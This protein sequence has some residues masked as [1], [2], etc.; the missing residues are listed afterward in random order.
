MRKIISL[1][2]A[3][4]F[5]VSFIPLSL[6]LKLVPVYDNY[7]VLIFAM[8]VAA[9]MTEIRIKKKVWTW[10]DLG[11]RRDTL[12][13]RSI[14][15]YFSITVIYLAGFYL[16]YGYGKKD[17]LLKGTTIM[18]SLLFSFSQ[19]FLY[20]GYLMKMGERLFSD[21]RVNI[22]VNTVLFTFMHAFFHLAPWSYVLIAIAGFGFAYSYD[23]YPNIYLVSLFHFMTNLMALHLGMFTPHF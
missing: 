3:E 20:R 22:A 9:T 15:F 1:P 5:A 13:L 23:R 19:E 21:R 16:L 11:F 2:A 17:M 12:T 6:V 7:L 18:A 4:F 10:S 8:L 14:R